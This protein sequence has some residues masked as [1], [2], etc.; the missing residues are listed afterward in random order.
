MSAHHPAEDCAEQEAPIHG[1]D[2]TAAENL[3]P[4]VDTLKRCGRFRDHGWLS[5]LYRVCAKGVCKRR[6]PAR[7]LHS[8]HSSEAG[9]ADGLGERVTPGETGEACEVCV[10]AVED[11]AV[12]DS[13][14]REV[15]I[16]CEVPGESDT[17]EKCAQAIGG[18]KGDVTSWGLPA[19]G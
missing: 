18:R 12:L 13:E 19:S 4:E 2:Q 9:D 7:L 17:T 11:S 15:G 1:E 5:V 6:V 3:A 16:C 14:G 8:A 10:G